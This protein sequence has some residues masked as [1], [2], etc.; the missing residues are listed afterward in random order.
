MNK[1]QKAWVRALRSGKYKQ[2]QSNLTKV[3]SNGTATT[4]C[5]LGVLCELAVKAGV[6][7]AV[8]NECAVRTYNGSEG[9]LPIE[10]RTW[11]GLRSS[12]GDFEPCIIAGEKCSDLSE[13]NDNAEKSFKFIASFIE[14][15]ASEL[16]VHPPYTGSKR[17]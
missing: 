13:V 4:H 5:C 7:I 1:I 10:V 14:K 12:C 6:P 3:D 9:S 15:K 17:K 11:A 2:T 16:F 8:K